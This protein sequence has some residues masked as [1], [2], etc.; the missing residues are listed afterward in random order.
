MLV[1][2]EGFCTEREGGRER[3]R[4]GEGRERERYANNIKM[5]LG[6]SPQLSSLVRKMLV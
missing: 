3:G 1:S 2:Q 4:G 6:N 5:F